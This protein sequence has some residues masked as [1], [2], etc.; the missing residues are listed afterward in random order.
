MCSSKQHLCECAHLTWKKSTEQSWGQSVL[1]FSEEEQEKH[2]WRRSTTAYE[3]FGSL[4]H[5]NLRIG[6]LMAPRL[7]CSSTCINFISKFC[8]TSSSCEAD[9][10]CS[11]LRCTGLP[12]AS[13]RAEFA[14]RIAPT[15]CQPQRGGEQNCA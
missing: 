1:R 9:D 14:V 15:Q 6:M 2:M 8:R 5:K 4:Q 11:G 3:S 10:R 12:S 7:S 13:Y